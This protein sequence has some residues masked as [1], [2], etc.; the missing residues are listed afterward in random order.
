MQMCPFCNK[1]YDESEYPHCPYCSGELDYENEEDDDLWTEV[2][3]KECP[4][5]KENMYFNKEDKCWICPDC[6]EV[7][8]GDEADND[9]ITIKKKS[10]R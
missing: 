9:G 7:I 8:Y 10:I 2:F 5:C 1:V 4:T 3:F 6:D